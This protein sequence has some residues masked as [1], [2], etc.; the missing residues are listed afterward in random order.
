MK[1]SK[2]KTFN[3]TEERDENVGELEEKTLNLV[4]KRAAR[5]GKKWGRA[6]KLLGL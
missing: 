4:L 3:T 1:V 2:G 5:R 6:K